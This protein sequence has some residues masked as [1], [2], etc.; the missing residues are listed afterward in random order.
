VKEAFGLI[1]QHR[2]AYLAANFGFYG[3][4]ILGFALAFAY[5]DLQR[6]L[7]GT[8]LQGFESGPL[9]IARDAYLSGNVPAAALITFLVNTVLGAFVALTIPSLLIPFAGF[10]IGVYRALF[11]GIA[12]AP[13][14]PEMAMAMIPHSLTILLEGQGYV[15]AMFGSYLLWARALRS[16]HYG[17]PDFK[18]GYWSG[19]KANAR[20]YLLIVIILAVAA[21]YEALEII[22][23]VGRQ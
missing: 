1:H 9:S 15:L 2:A 6:Q 3:L 17:Y 18:A 22:Y 14:T 23:I 12:L 21:V 10:G 7:I 11:L 5:P 16:R 8:I 19:L 13:T 20:L 4:M